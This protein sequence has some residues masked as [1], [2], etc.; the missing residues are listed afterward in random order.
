MEK[1][2][3]KIVFVTAALLAYSSS[4]AALPNA[5]KT[6]TAIDILKEQA[7]IWL[8]TDL[9]SPPPSSCAQYK[10][11]SCTVGTPFCDLMVDVALAAKAMGK[12]VEF[13]FED[14]CNGSFGE[15]SRFRMMN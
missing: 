5:E 7:V 14:S 3:S 12:K 2:F 15:A 10:A 1:I 11:V 13:A 8:A 6:V 4:Q 9:S